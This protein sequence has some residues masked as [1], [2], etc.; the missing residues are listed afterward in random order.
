MSFKTYK[1]IKPKMVTLDSSLKETAGLA[2]QSSQFIQISHK[3]PCFLTQLQS[4]MLK[5]TTYQISVE[6]TISLTPKIITLDNLVSHLQARNIVST[7]EIRWRLSRPPCSRSHSIYI[8]KLFMV[9]PTEHNKKES[10][11]FVLNVA[12]QYMSE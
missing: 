8:I 4:T 9:I 11:F 1:M 6:A 12:E 10:T 3:G 2:T 5:A 7:L